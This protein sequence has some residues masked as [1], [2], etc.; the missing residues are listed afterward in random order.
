MP[1]DKK[2]KSVTLIPIEVR[3]DWAL[4]SECR[5][6]NLLLNFNFRRSRNAIYAIHTKFNSFMYTIG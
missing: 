3:A 6:E 2:S 1:L 5:T 4:C